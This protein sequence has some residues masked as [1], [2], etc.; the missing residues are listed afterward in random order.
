[1]AATPDLATVKQRQQAF[2]S[3][4]VA[5]MN[6]QN[7]ATDGTLKVRNEYLEAVVTRTG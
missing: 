4:M 3:E 7:E 5:L 1:M 6:T 2:A